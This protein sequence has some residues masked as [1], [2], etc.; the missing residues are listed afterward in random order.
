MKLVAKYPLLSQLYIYSLGDKFPRRSWL[1]T[2]N[3]IVDAFWS[4]F[5]DGYLNVRGL[6]ESLKVIRTEEELT[7]EFRGKA[8]HIDAF[9]EALSASS[10]LTDA[11]REGVFYYYE[12]G[13]FPGFTFRGLMLDHHISKMV[14]GQVVDNF[15]TID[16]MSRAVQKLYQQYV[17]QGRYSRD[18]LLGIKVALLGSSWTEYMLLPEVTYVGIVLAPLIP[19]GTAVAEYCPSS[20]NLLSNQD[21][22]D[23]SQ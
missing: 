7:L 3:C 9:T 11:D 13:A 4:T 6:F 20:G 19:P 22:F 18:N 23:G 17:T 12:R 16:S 2:P 8:W 14:L 1:I 5:Y 15:D 10:P 21:D